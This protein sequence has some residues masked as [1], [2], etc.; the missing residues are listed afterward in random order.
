MSTAILTPELRPDSI[1]DK[2]LRGAIGL[3]FLVAALGQWAFVHYVL[4]FYGPSTLT[5]N[6]E[7]WSRN[8]MLPKG[9][10]PGDTAGNLFFAG[11]VLLA[12]IVTFGGVLQLVPRIRARALGFH[13]WNGRLFLVTAVATSLAGLYMIW[14]GGRGGGLEGRLALSLNAV[15]IFTFAALAWRAAATHQVAAHRRWALRAYLAANAVWFLRVGFM[16]WAMASQG[17]GAASFYRFWEFGCYLLPLGVLELYLRTREGAG[18]GR[19]LAM[20]GLL[21]A[22]TALMG[23]GI[24]ALHMGMLLPLLRS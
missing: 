13:R 15:L 20:A 10:V 21:L 8:K 4:A 3:W 19:R 9:Y 1:A 2:A 14:L 5:G 23:A 18:A 24:F 16:A 22:L 6:F 17:R 7:A 11:H 12:A